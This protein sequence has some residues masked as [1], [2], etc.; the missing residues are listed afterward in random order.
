MGVTLKV[1][2]IVPVFNGEST[3]SRAISSVN[4]QTRSALE[5]IV[6]DDASTDA[7]A[8]VLGQL[9]RSSSTPLIIVT[10]PENVGPGISR[11]TG[12]VLARGDLIA[13]LDADDTWHPQKLE[14]QVPRFE[15]NSKLKMACHDRSVGSI[16]SWQP[17]DSRGVTW[18][19]F[20]F[21]HFLVRNRCATPSVIVRKELPERF[22]TSLRFAE[23]FHLW[24][25]LTSTY[26]PVSYTPEVLV[27]CENPSY[28]G[29]GLSGNYWMMFQSE[30]RALLLLAKNGRLSW[31]LLPLVIMWSTT[32]FGIRLIDSTVLGNRLQTV[33]ES[34]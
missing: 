5:I 1:S 27:H 26:G 33:S 8:A 3:I 19:D 16:L 20:A 15:S 10:N 32:K 4:E 6:I 9:T 21:K 34:R 17:I 11:N 29:A 31:W 23:D 12:W 28:G 24:L 7:T 2:V 14:L 13:F 18:R 30:A 22:D 25:T